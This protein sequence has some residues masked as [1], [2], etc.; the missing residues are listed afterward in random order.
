MYI[1]GEMFKFWR[2]NVRI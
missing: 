2:K 1:L